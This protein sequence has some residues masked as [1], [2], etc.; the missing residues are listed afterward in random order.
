VVRAH[1]TTPQR[2][3]HPGRGQRAAIDVHHRDAGGAF[4]GRDHGKRS[5]SGAQV[6]HAPPGRCPI[7]SEDLGEQ[8][9]VV[10]W[11][12]HARRP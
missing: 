5:G 6:E 8:P 10:L 3:V 12:V 2:H 9:G 7:A 1:P 11:R 4:T